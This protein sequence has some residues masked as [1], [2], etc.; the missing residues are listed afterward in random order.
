MQTSM[1]QP[2]VASIQ[3]KYEAID[4]EMSLDLTPK[5]DDKEKETFD[6]AVMSKS[7]VPMKNYHLSTGFKN[8]ISSSRGSQEIKKE[9]LTTA[10][11]KATSPRKSQDI[12]YL[13]HH[14]KKSELSA[15]GP[16]TKDRK[17]VK[18]VSQTIV[19]ESPKL[20]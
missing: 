8:P 13:A 6:K 1:N 17:P 11:G 9:A 4:D 7:A 10:F 2:T 14:K 18:R 16:D 12:S 19:A 20:K 3:E 15:L 5:E